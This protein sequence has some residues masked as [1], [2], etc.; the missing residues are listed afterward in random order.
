MSAEA[1]RCHARFCETPTKPEMLMCLKHW[2][3]VPKVLQHE[4]WLHYRPGQ[5]DDKEPSNAWHE[6][7]DAAIEAVLRKECAAAKA[8]GGARL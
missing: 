7:A 6:A 8:R 1:H 2:R 5:C 3:M 4:V